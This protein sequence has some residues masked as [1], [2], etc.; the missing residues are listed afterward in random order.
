MASTLTAAVRSGVSAPIRSGPPVEVAISE[1]TP[2]HCFTYSDEGHEFFVIRFSDRPAWVF[3][4]KT[5]RWHERGSGPTWDAWEII[6]TARL[7]GVWYGVNTL[8]KIYSMSRTNDDAGVALS[9]MA[10]S[11][12]L[13]RGG[14]FFTVHRFELLGEVGTSDIPS[15][16]LLDP[17]GNPL[18][19]P[20]GNPIFEINGTVLDIGR[21]VTVAL[22]VSRDGGLTWEPEIFRSF[23]KV[24]NYRQRATWNALG[25]SEQMAGRVIVTDKTDVNIYSNVNVEAA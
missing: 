22:Q 4:V 23:G 10:Q 19:D 9:R 20:D 7:D 8:G 1:S 25:G 3:D 6:A 17:D 13:Y 21:A 18:S 24:G 2:T 14:E 11:N 16:L 5:R 15:D 12:L